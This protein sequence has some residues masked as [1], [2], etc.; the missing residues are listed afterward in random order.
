MDEKI[1]NAVFIT[2]ASGF[3]ALYVI[4]ELLEN[5]YRVYATDVREHELSIVSHQ[6]DNF[7]FIKDEFRK[8]KK[9]IEELFQ[10]NKETV[11]STLHFAGISD[12]NTCEK[13]PLSAYDAN[14]N[15]TMEVLDF[16]KEQN[17]SKFYYPSTAHVYGE[18]IINQSSSE[19]SLI[20]PLNFYAWT[21]YITEKTI[22]SFCASFGL[23]ATVM[24]FNNIIGYPLK[25]GT[26][27]SDIYRQ[28][29][30]GA[31]EV[32]IKNG[33]PVRD[34]IFVKDAVSALVFLLNRDS[35]SNFEVYNI[36]SGKG[37]S[38]MEFARL[39]CTANDLPTSFAK[40]QV[41][42]DSH[43]PVLVLDNTKLKQTG[44]SSLYSIEASLQ[45]IN[46]M[47]ANPL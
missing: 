1:N 35:G 27:L 13:N 45:E 40:S 20:N 5:N 41:P 25:T 19:E 12:A 14:V 43:P 26:I 38:A 7:F 30:N 8:A 10:D 32:V 6:A 46:G 9:D 42:T 16:C 17:I 23:Q 11:F 33:N 3:L 47:M 21:K 15:L 37:V 18:N 4:A 28:I 29:R 36:S 2:G 44:W 24:R 22:E 34:Y 39:V 31:K